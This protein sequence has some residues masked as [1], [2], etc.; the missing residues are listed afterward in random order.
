MSQLGDLLAIALGAKLRQARIRRGLTAA[1]VA[2]RIGSHRP[3]VSRTERG[4]HVPDLTHLAKHAHA[5]GLDLAVIG[6]CIDEVSAAAGVEV[7]GPSARSAARVVGPRRTHARCQTVRSRR[8]SIAEAAKVLD[9]WR[10]RR[11]A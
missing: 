7:W 2:H 3:I 8:R 1:D 6:S 9:E 5:V 10:V 11:A 4:H